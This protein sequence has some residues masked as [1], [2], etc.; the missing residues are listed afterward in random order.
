MY[1]GWGEV[2]M[3]QCTSSGR[4]RTRRGSVAYTVLILCTCCCCSANTTINC[5]GEMRRGKKCVVL[6]CLY[7]LALNFATF[8]FFS[9]IIC[10][11]TNH[12]PSNT[13]LHQK[14]Y[15]PPSS[16]YQPSKVSQHIGYHDRN[17][18]CRVL[19]FVLLASRFS[20]F[21]LPKLPTLLK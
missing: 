2:R 9:T 17:D 20:A 18:L 10:S 4:I 8:S 6:Y 14:S 16:F 5:I 15:Q 3:W 11:H 1:M 13:T 19:H 12:Q 7:Q 21:Q